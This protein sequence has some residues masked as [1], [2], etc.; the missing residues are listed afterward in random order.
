[1]SPLPVGSKGSECIMNAAT[2]VRVIRCDISSTL[3][4]TLSSVEAESK[5]VKATLGDFPMGTKLTFT[6]MFFNNATQSGPWKVQAVPV[7]DNYLLRYRY[8][9][10]FKLSLLS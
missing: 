9:T 2:T 1:M 4:L 8:R 3:T 6:V 5:L 10:H 7:Q